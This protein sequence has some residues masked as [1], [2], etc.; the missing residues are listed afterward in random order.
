MLNLTPVQVAVGIALVIGLFIGALVL[1]LQFKGSADSPL[2]ITLVPYQ[3]KSA[4]A[5]PMID[6]SAPVVPPTSGTAVGFAGYGRTPRAQT[7]DLSIIAHHVAVPVH[8]TLGE[9]AE[10]TFRWP[11][12]DDD[13]AGTTAYH[14]LAFPEPPG[15]PNTPTGYE[16]QHDVSVTGVRYRVLISETALTIGTTLET[17]TWTT[18]TVGE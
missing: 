5:A 17:L 18:V 4:D 7:A 15:H 6:P 12:A 8:W 3:A 14:W 9:T 1:V 10:T 16:S 11:S 13:W 2:H